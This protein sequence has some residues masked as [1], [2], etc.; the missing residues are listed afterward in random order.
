MVSEK[1]MIAGSGIRQ[2][3]YKNNQG[4]QL[5]KEQCSLFL[6]TEKPSVKKRAEASLNS[7]N[8]WSLLPASSPVLRRKRQTQDCSKFIP[9]RAFPGGMY[10]LPSF[11][12]S[13]RHGSITPDIAGLTDFR[14]HFLH[15]LFQ[16]PAE[17]GSLIDTIQRTHGP[18][19]GLQTRGCFR[20]CFWSWSDIKNQYPL[21]DFSISEDDQPVSKI[22]TRCQISH[23]WRGQEISGKNR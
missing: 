4:T 13:V 10:L 21:P 14:R 18:Y 5:W 12:K 7:V 11:R 19:D 9:D 23:E 20:I 22:G 8:S 2:K 16:C 1:C 17:A 3:S 15:I 6:L